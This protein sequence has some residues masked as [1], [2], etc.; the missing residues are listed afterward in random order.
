MML[1]YRQK[2]GSTNL[3]LIGYGYSTGTPVFEPGFTE[4]FEMTRQDVLSGELS[5][6]SASPSDSAVYY[7]AAKIHTKANCVEFKQTPALIA[8]ETSNIS[9]ECS[10]DDNGLPRMLW[11]QQSS[12]TVMAL[13]GYTAGPS[14]DPNYEG[15]TD[16]VTQTPSI[17]A[18]E[19][20]DITIQC[21]HDD[22]NLHNMYWYQQNSMSVM[23]LIGYSVGATGDPKED[24]LCNNISTDS[25]DSSP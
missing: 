25:I 17:I 11:Y 1:W 21:S 16:G 12:R 7:C 5:I 9:L 23:T 19:T 18:T 20:S 8:N 6:S 15:R 4:G 2:P 10:H 24:K 13:I 14:T 3:S 22:S